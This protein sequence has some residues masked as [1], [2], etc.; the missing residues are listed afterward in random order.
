M[1]APLIITEMN[2]PGRTMISFFALLT[3]DSARLHS[4]FHVEGCWWG[5]SRKL[6]L[7]AEWQQGLAPPQAPAGR[8]LLLLANL[9]GQCG[10]L[11]PASEF[12]A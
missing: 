6:P 4:S 11:L 8:V 5:G 12:A 3:T 7:L 9:S 1:N 10:S 2:K